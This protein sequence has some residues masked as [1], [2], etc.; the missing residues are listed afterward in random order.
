MVLTA[1][2]LIDDGAVFHLNGT[3]V[4]RYNMPGGP[5]TSATL[6]SSAVNN[7]TT[8]EVLSLPS[9]SLVTGRNVLAVEV[10][11]AAPNDSD[12]AFDASLSSS[13]M[14]MICSS[15]SR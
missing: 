12:M 1:S 3:E 13:V 8:F 7:A 6:A 4:G 5:V 11:Q 15:L 10:H 14:E 9:D 2:N